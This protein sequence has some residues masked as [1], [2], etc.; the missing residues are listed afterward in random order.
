M[1]NVK[2]WLMRGRNLEAEIKQLEKAKTDAFVKACGGAIDTSVE[3]VQGGGGNGTEEKFLKYI[4]YDRMIN[5]RVGELMAVK[6]EII[7]CINAVEKTIYRAVLIAYYINCMTWE[8]VAE[9]LGYEVRWIY[10]LHKK[11]IKD[12]VIHYKGMV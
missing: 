5:E 10:Q 6:A 12:I 9:E 1:D 2:E 3:R 8:K 7:K 4:E 11:A